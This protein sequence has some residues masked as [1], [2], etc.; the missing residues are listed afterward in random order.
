MLF[1]EDI[2]PI[3]SNQHQYNTRNKSSTEKQDFLPANE[4]KNT[5]K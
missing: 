4:A 1:E 3:V 2:D 5:E